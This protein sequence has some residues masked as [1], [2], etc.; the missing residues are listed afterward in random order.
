LKEISTSSAQAIPSGRL[1]FLVYQGTPA[2][3]TGD[4]TQTWRSFNGPDGCMMEVGNYVGSGLHS[5]FLHLGRKSKCRIPYAPV[6]CV[7]N[8]DLGSCLECQQ[9]RRHH[10]RPAQ[11][12]NQLQSHTHNLFHR[13]KNYSDLLY[14][15]PSPLRSHTLKLHVLEPR[16]LGSIPRLAS[17]LQASQYLYPCPSLHRNKYR[18]LWVGPP[19]VSFSENGAYTLPE[20][21]SI[22][23]C[24]PQWSSHAF[25][26]GNFFLFWES[27]SLF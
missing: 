13:T 26:L 12:H 24:N 18:G 10:G 11:P 20:Q 4:A 25:V 22:L 6:E 15:N 14:T 3:N 27:F 9:A 7:T 5:Q 21:S 16:S 2:I 1:P 23:Q 17:R 8:V 19:R